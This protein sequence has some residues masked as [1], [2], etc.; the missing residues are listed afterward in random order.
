M[1]TEKTPRTEAP[2]VPDQVKLKAVQA[3]RLASISGVDAKSLT[4]LTVAQISD[5]FRFQI[6]PRL[7]FFR[8]VCGTVVKKDPVTGNNLRD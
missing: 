6:D 7:L 3:E 4:G 1:A 8:K 5:K 2:A